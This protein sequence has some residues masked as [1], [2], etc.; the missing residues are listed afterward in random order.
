MILQVST[1][2]R[3]DPARVWKVLID[4]AG[5]SRWI[6]F[7]TVDVVSDQDQGVGVRAVALS[8]FRVGRLPIGLLDNF[9]VTRWTPPT[10]LE[11]A[12]LGPYFTGTGLFR[13]EAVGSD[14][15]AT[16]TEVFH[17]PG[18]KPVE[19]LVR[20]VLPLMRIGFRRSLRGLATIAET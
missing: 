1:Q 11:V 14:T 12:H 4:W 19:A 3:A 7:T 20:I 6:P 8:G 16:A 18:G 5:Q 9:I 13:L 10:E 15:L 2:V 17:V